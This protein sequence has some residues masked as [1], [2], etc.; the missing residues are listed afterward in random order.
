MGAYQPN[1]ALEPTAYSFG[2]ASASGGGSPPAF[3]FHGKKQVGMR[4]TRGDHHV[5]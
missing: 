2:F 4:R 5:V 1:Q 3:G